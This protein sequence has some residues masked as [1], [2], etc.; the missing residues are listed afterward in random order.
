M[1]APGQ[2]DVPALRHRPPRDEHVGAVGLRSPRRAPLRR[3]AL[4][5]DL[6]G[7]R[8]GRQSGVAGRAGRPGGV[9]RRVGRDLRHLRR[10]ARLPAAR[11]P[12]RRSDRVPLAVLGRRRVR[13]GDARPRPV[14]ARHRQRRARRRPRDRGAARRGGRPPAVGRAPPVAAAARAAAAMLVAAIALFA[15]NIPEPRYRFGEELQARSA[16]RQFLDDE[17]R[18][19]ERWEQI[20]NAGRSGSASFDELAGDI[21]ADVSKEY[22][23]SFEQLSSVA[24]SPTRAVGGAISRSCANTRCCAATRRMRWPR[25]CGRTTRPAS[26]GPSRRCAARRSSRRR[27]RAPHRLRHLHPHLHRRRRRHPHRHRRP[28]ASRCDR[29]V[30]GFRSPPL[31]RQDPLQMRA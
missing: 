8:P 10:A 2:R 28:P 7:E 20:V 4:A 22:Q 11:A 16:I 1:V 3:A 17:H 26:S 15:F 12:A 21:D 13:A 19:G 18:I 5:A 31:T 23:D 27:H 14:R 30:E 24:V 9:R 29:L 25:R 6:R